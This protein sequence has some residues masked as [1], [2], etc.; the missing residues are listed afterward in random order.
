MMSRRR[1]F[2]LI[3]LLVVISII[4]ILAAMLFP[5]FA[6]AREAARKIQCLSNVKNI[7]MAF[8]MYLTDY[9]RFPPSLSTSA[10]NDVQALLAAANA[11]R[12]NKMCQS[13]A[14]QSDPYLRWPVI[15]D[16][17]IKNRDVWNCPSPRL[18]EPYDVVFDPGGI[19][20]WAHWMA[21]HPFS[22]WSG[23]YLYH[24]C[25]TYFPGSW[26]GAITDSVTS[27]QEVSYIGSEGAAEAQG[28]YGGSIGTTEGNNT[29]V[30]TSQINDPAHFV[31]AGDSASPQMWS[32]NLDAWDQCGLWAAQA[33]GCNYADWSNCSFTVSCGLTRDAFQRF[34]TDPSYRK[35]M[36]RHLG[37]TNIGFADG[38]ASWWPAEAF[39]EACP[40]NDCTGPYP[41]TQVWHDG[42]IEG[43]SSWNRLLLCPGWGS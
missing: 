39:V 26:G 11:G 24:P 5:V 40:H 27:F 20:G 23:Q 32:P 25:E 33:G 17:Y 3:E 29:D 41:G 31:V 19:N 1:G 38:H 4:A 15:L 13:R 7:A 12:G 9:D 16:E 2:T 43:A 36:T 6:R 30:R 8:Q 37:G 28:A 42:T 35:T 10:Y 18:S 22:G 34:W 14:D 21:N